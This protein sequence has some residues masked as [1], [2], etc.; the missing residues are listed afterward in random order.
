VGIAPGD[1]VLDL[2]AG[3]GAVTLP[4]LAATGTTGALLAVDVAP[5]VVERLQ[6]RLRSSGH[7]D[8]RAVLGD[9]AD[10]GHD[11]ARYDVVLCGFGL[12]FLPDPPAALRRWAGLLAPDGRLG[13]STWGREDE[14]FG[15][16]RHEVV[17]LG[18]DA[19]PR[20][21]AYDDP[22]VLRSVLA[23]AGLREVAV[24][25][26]SL[27]LVLADVDELLRWAGTH[28]ARAWLAQL[29]L[30]QRRRLRDV[31]AAHWPGPV[32]MTWQAHL[33]SGSL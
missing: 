16:L 4:A 14:V 11:A 27:D 30:G 15:A 26:V 25:T 31:L 10:P 6:A 17:R 8:A 18:V 7:P 9:A 22:A 3:S 2:A 20:G 5:G 32:P 21:Q 33:A 24:T 23:G 13:L 28:G 29:E 1:R 19:R 12:F